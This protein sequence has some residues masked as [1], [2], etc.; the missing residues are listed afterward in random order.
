MHYNVKARNCDKKINTHR[1]T[2]THT[3]LAQEEESNANKKK[4]NKSW[5]DFDRKGK[6]GEV[7]TKN[8]NREE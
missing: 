3:E 1:H 5:N 6:W 2:H 4:T 7:T 8:N